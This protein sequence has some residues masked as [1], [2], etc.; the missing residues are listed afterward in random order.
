MKSCFAGPIRQNLCAPFDLWPV[1]SASKAWQHPCLARPF[2]IKPAARLTNDRTLTTYLYPVKQK[3]AL[4]KSNPP[5][6][7]WMRRRNK[8]VSAFWGGLKPPQKGN[9]RPLFES[10]LCLENLTVPKYKIIRTNNKTSPKI[11]V[12]IFG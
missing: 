5:R 7:N 4:L 10:L 9:W 6:D 8:N 3:R 12:H 1:F 11:A 2:A